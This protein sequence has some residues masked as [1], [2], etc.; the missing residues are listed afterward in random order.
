MT[1]IY[2]ILILGAVVFVHEL[3]HFLFA[4][5][6]KVHVYEFAIGMGKKIFS[7]KKKG[8]VV[9]KEVLKTISDNEY[10][11]VCFYYEFL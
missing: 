8:G 4:R 3:G 11:V 7:Y 6:A 9:K 1:L 10:T 2:F 5:L